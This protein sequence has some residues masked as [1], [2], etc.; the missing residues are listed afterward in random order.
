MNLSNKLNNLP[1]VY[2]MNL[3]NRIDRREYMESQFTRWGITNYTRVSGTRFLAS[4]IE[5]WR[6]LVHG[7]IYMFGRCPAVTANAMTHVLFF[8]DWLE[9]TDEQY[10][11][12]MEDDVDLNLIEYWHFDWD[13]LMAHIPY[14]WDCVQLGYESQTTVQFFLHPKPPVRT[15][16][17]PCLLNRRYVK[18]LVDLHFRD[19]VFIFDHQVNN[20]QLLVE[21]GST[22]VDYFI[23]ENGRTYCLPLLTVN[24]DFGSY[25]HNTPH[26]IDHHIRCRQLYYDFWTTDRDKFSLEEFF[27]YGKPND[28]E[29]TKIVFPE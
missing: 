27:V 5:Q 18:K 23:A 4:E 11:I 8:K 13:F 12:I 16:F 14:D 19:G 29:M 6:H 3:D 26:P 7:N 17:G 9:Q 24:N 20:Y 28:S 22:T 2:Y 15:Y 21:G 1:H 25:E 10:M